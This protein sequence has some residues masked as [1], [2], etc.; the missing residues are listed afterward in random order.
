MAADGV[1]PLG[2]RQCAIGGGGLPGRRSGRGSARA[3]DRCGWCDGA[4]A[5]G[6]RRRRS[7]WPGGSFAGDVPGVASP[8]GGGAGRRAA[9]EGPAAARADGKTGRA[10]CGR[11]ARSGAAVRS[12]V[13]SASVGRGLASSS[14]KARS[15]VAARMRRAA[16][17][18]RSWTNMCSQS[19]RGAR[20][21]RKRGGTPAGQPEDADAFCNGACN[22]RGGESPAGGGRAAACRGSAMRV[23]S[24]RFAPIVRLRVV[25]APDKDRSRAELLD[26]DASV[27]NIVELRGAVRGPE[28]AS[29]SSAALARAAVVRRGRRGVP[30]GDRRRRAVVAAVPGDRPGTVTGS[31]GQLSVR[32]PASSARGRA[33]C[34]SSNEVSPLLPRGRGGRARPRARRARR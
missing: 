29:R 1:L 21:E 6:S 13:L 15:H 16:R 25:S 32:S 9:R 22:G 19:Y 12:S 7:A 28:P 27:S 4:L 18:V 34:S 26:A 3:G 2:V 23:A 33:R 20:T 30:A 5:A 17:R 8:G 31:L 14:A 24:S 11:A 10:R